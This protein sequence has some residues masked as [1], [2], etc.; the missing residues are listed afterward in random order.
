MK[1][2]RLEPQKYFL[3][4]A[5]LEPE[6]NIE[7]ILDS[8]TLSASEYPF[9]VIGN[10]TTKYGCFLK[11]KYTK[12]D[13]RFVGSIYD[14]NVLDSL[15]KYALGYFHGHSVGGTNPSLLEAMGSNAFII[16]HDNEFN[17]SVLQQNALYFSSTSE[18]VKHIDG[19]PEFPSSEKNRM[20]QN[21]CELIK[22]NYSWEYIAKEYEKIFMSVLK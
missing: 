8:Y 1:G 2:Y 18:L 12:K 9:I 15:R 21:N 17:K 7:L 14:K 6:N 19:L 3:L 13:V 5:R 11:D 4:I 16:A 20:I 22:A 10:Y